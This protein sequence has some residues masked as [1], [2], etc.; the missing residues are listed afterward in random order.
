VALS[1]I[2]ASLPL[3]GTLSGIG[4]APII[5]FSQR[6]WL[7]SFNMAPSSELAALLLFGSLK[8]HWLRSMRMALSDELATLSV[9]GSLTHNGFNAAAE[10]SA[11]GQTVSQSDKAPAP[12]CHGDAQTT[13]REDALGIA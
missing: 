12:A 1:D 6:S 9:L 8:F 13:R 2:G 5:W 7:R 10:C 4:C 11:Y 3:H